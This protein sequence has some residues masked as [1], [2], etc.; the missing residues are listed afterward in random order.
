MSLSVSVDWSTVCVRLHHRFLGVLVGF[1]LGVV[2]VFVGVL[3]GCGCGAGVS[4][5]VAFCDGVCGLEPA[6]GL[7][8]V[9]D[10]RLVG[11]AQ[12]CS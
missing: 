4:W 3:V 6:F 2:V 12:A 11:P 9:L 5:V 10:L 1:F 7:C 8:S